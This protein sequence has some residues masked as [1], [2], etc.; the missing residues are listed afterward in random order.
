MVYDAMLGV[1][2]SGSWNSSKA[3]CSTGPY[4]RR[5]GGNTYWNCP[6]WTRDPTA[7]TPVS[8]CSYVLGNTSF[9][10]TTT[11]PD[12]TLV[13][14]TLT[15]S[16]PVT[17]AKLVTTLLRNASAKVSSFSSSKSMEVNFSSKVSTVWNM[18]AR[19]NPLD[20]CASVII[21]LKL[22]PS[23]STWG[24]SWRFLRLMVTTYVVCVRESC[25]VTTSDTLL[26][27]TCRSTGG[28]GCPPGVTK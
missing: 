8:P 23:V 6:L 18:L 14:R 3:C 9:K 12:V 20:A 4:T 26:G 15:G 17:L 7:A 5:A 19:P 28:M 24:C 2:P 10:P 16:S 25:A 1:K 22:S 27:P 11:L 21:W 13:I